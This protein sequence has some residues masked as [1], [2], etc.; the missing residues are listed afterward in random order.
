[1]R[2]YID[3]ARLKIKLVGIALIC[4]SIIAVGTMVGALGMKLI[5]DQLIQIYD[6][7]LVIMKNVSRVVSMVHDVRGDAYNYVLNSATRSATSKSIVEHNAEIQKTIDGLR[8]MPLDDTDQGLI[9]DLNAAWT[10]Y[11]TALNQVLT[12]ASIGKEGAAITSMDDGDALAAYV[13]FDQ[14]NE[15]IIALL[16]EHASSS[17]AQSDLI[18]AV[19][20]SI[21]VFGGILGVAIVIVLGIVVSVSVTSAL[22]QAVEMIQEMG[23]GHLRSRLQMER[24]DEIG[25]LARTMDQF[26]DDLQNVVIGTMQKISAGDLSMTVT[27]KDAQDEIS[28]ALIGTMLSLRGLVEETTRLTN[29]AVDGKLST[30]A[31][32]NKF[33][34]EYRA[35][36]QGVNDTLDAV[37]SPLNMAAEYVDLISQGEIPV[38]ITGTYN[39]DFNEIINNLNQCINGL[40][41]LVES[42]A[43]LQ[44]MAVNDYTRQVDGQY[45]G[46]FASVATATN[47]VRNRLLQVQ[48]IATNIAQGDLQD[49][50]DLRAIG[51]RSE[52]DQLT[53]AFAHMIEAIQAM[54]NDA[55][56]LNQAALAQQFETRADAT[57][58]QGDF[59]KIIEGVNQTLDTVVDQVFWYEQLLDAIP[60]GL[61]VTDLKMQWTFINKPVEQFLGIR[62]QDVTGK[63]CKNWNSAICQTENCGVNKLRH[64]QMQTAFKQNGKDF[65][66]DS[67]YLVNQ[68]GDKTGHVEVIRDV[69]ATAHRND[70]TRTELERFTSNMH[71]FAQGNLD[72]DLTMTTPDD[73]SRVIYDNYKRLND[74]M[75]TVRNSVAALL[76]D[77]NT[78]SQSAVEGKLAIRAD[79]GNHGGDFRKIVQGV[80]A[81]LD[82]VINPIAETKDILGRIA[83][84]DLIVNLNGHY[85][86]DFV[87]LKDSI[88]AMTHNLREMAMQSQQ[89]AGNVS[90]ASAQILASSIQTA[91]ATRE[92]A[93]AVNQV[94]STVREI[95]TSAEQVAQRAQSVAEQAS[96]ASRV[97]QHGNE[98]VHA[99]MTAMT[100]I[101]RKVEAIAENILALSEQTQQIGEIIDTVTDIADQSN[102]LALNAAIEA[103][104]AGEAG[105]GFRVVAEE[106]RSLS[107]QS[108]QAAAQVKVILGDIQKATNLAVLATEQGTKGVQAGSEQVNRTMQTIQE[109]ASV[110]DASSQ[111]AQQIVAGVAQQAIGLDQIVIG[112]SDI[113]QAAQQSAAGA[114]QTQQAA[115]DMN[116]SAE[117]MKRIVAQYRM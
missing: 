12:N 54:A 8:A 81:T 27:A 74:S 111:A 15:K 5:N 87:M 18:F 71:R 29:A 64:D 2:K 94:S 77:V 85:K 113:N 60:V 43:V 73:Y 40:G 61:S 39:G 91:G 19:A 53:P 14:A 4:A 45:Q 70:F 50:Q 51:R 37:I 28:P 66:I 86:G 97:A 93:G 11:Q 88:E 10:K 38:K 26:A 109:L 1:M 95:K 108:R 117:Q 30:R 102:I 31:D 103:A 82:S 55:H 21:A 100:D 78:L 48:K 79:A 90:S 34:G 116:V 57:Q 92:Q 107:V 65:Q 112:M 13:M 101:H 33:L 36:V 104:Q 110:V 25:T 76:T 98:A 67:A 17:K 75:C 63:P 46:I 9:Y 56:R 58:H 72:W 89:S 69:T 16:S 59:R 47:D 96:R 80:N 20:S 23:K 68:R 6:R 83:Q 84:G 114:Q 106:V 22:S 42:N 49:L 24:Q 99:A 105:K 115:Q 35:V 52:N 44:R 32:V 62:R 3:N 7:E 41:G